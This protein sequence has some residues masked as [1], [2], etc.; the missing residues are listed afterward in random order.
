MLE[1]RLRKKRVHCMAKLMEERLSLCWFKDLR[2]EVEHERYQRQL[3]HAICQ[4]ALAPESEMG[5]ARKLVWP[6]AR[7]RALARK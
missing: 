6:S 5:T 1:L 2:S 3:R 4:L 7:A